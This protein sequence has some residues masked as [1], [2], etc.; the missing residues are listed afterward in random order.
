MLDTPNYTPGQLQTLRRFFHG[1]NHFMV[2]MWK[3]GLGRMINCWPAGFGRI[4]V[5]RHRGRKTGKE[6]LTPVNYAI[7]ED[8]I[9]CTAGFGPRTDSYR[10]LLA[11]PGVQLWLPQGKRQARAVD[12]S[13]SPRRA[14]LLRAIIIASGFAGPLMGV[15]QRKL[16]DA[17]MAVIGK[18]YRLVHF[19]LES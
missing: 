14:S 19:Q 7:V 2:F 9:Y 3:L 17:Q 11:D 5:I 4:L 13:D 12:V 10:N 1:M 6:Y 16:T 15:N 18:D 8:E